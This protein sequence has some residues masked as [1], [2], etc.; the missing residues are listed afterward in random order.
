MKPHTHSI[1]LVIVAAAAASAAPHPLAAQVIAG[2]VIE[3]TTGDPMPDVTVQLLDVDARAVATTLSDQHGR[4]RLAAPRGGEWRITAEH[5]GYRRAEA[6]G[7]DVLEGATLTVEIRMSVQPVALDS[8]IIVTAESTFAS[9]DLERFHQR[10]LEGTGFGHFIYGESIRRGIGGRP[11]DLLRSVPGVRINSNR[12]GTGSVIHMRAGCVPAVFVDGMEI[13]RFSSSES[14]DHYLSV[15]DIEGIEVYRGIPPDVRYY[16]RKGCG[17]VLVWT[18]RGEPSGSSG[19][20]LIRLLV[21]V[22]LVAVLLA[23]R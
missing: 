14:L 8:S 15:Q 19:S 20:L 4:F 12:G 21:A 10:R 23:V 22:G 11:T 16:D 9:H 6:S 18:R 2:V 17:V 1:A 5:L 7:L 13:N 3:H